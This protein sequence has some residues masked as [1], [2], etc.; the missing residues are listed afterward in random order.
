MYLDSGNKYYLLDI[1]KK[2]LGALIEE[3]N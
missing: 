2:I 1:S 3:N